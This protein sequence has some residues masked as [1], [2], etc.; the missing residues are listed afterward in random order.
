VQTLISYI[1]LTDDNTSL[2]VTLSSTC[3]VALNC[4]MF[5][6]TGFAYFP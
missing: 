2:C 6:Y 5:S 4:S 3:S 1:V